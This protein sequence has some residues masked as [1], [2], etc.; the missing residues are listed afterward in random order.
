MN[1]RLIRFWEVDWNR[2]IP[3]PSLDAFPGPAQPGPVFQT[4]GFAPES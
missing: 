1:G 2:K 3:Q 4:E